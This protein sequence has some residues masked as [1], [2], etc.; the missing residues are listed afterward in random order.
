MSTVADPQCHALRF[1]SITSRYAIRISGWQ[2]SEFTAPGSSMAALE[3][4]REGTAWLVFT[5]VAS[6]FQSLLKRCLKT[7]PS[8]GFLHRCQDPVVPS[9]PERALCPE[10]VWFLLGSR[11]LTQWVDSHCFMTACWWLQKKQLPP[12]HQFFMV[13]AP[14]QLPVSPEVVTLMTAFKVLR[15]WDFLVLFCFLR[16]QNI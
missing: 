3:P 5:L 15:V 12:R 1:S 13:T 4:S 14:L 7:F 16:F 10:G 9:D 8:G 11:I 2:P 6:G